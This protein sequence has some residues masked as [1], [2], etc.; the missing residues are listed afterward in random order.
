[1]AVRIAEP[2]ADEGNAGVQPVEE[3][4]RGRRATPVVCHLED[5]HRRLARAPEPGRQ[6][7]WVDILLDVARE[8]HAAMRQ[9]Q[10]EH[11]R[12]VVDRAPVVRG[13]ERHLAAP[14]PQDVERRIVE[15]DAVSGSEEDGSEAE[16]GQDGAKGVVARSVAEHPGLGDRPDAVAAEEQRHPGNVVLV[17]MAEHQQVQSSVPCRNSLVET[18]QQQVRIGPAVD[19]HP[20]AARSLQEDGVALPDVQYGHPEATIRAARPDC[21]YD[22][23]QARGYCRHRAHAAPEPR[24][25]GSA[26]GLGRRGRHRALCHRRSCS[27]VARVTARG[28]AGVGWAALGAAARSHWKE[29]AESPAHGRPEEADADSRGGRGRQVEGWWQGQ[30]GE[31]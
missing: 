2:G 27:R 12:H 29:K 19:E 21:N 22:D 4:A 10:V 23:H 16:L 13:V 3:G 24:G 18:A 31:W 28:L 11:N 8:Q 30:A 14:R 17:R 5:V 15:L 25:M 20:G 9:S 1:M 26:T 7:L 6:Q